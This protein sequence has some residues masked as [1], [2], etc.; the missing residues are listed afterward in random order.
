MQNYNQNYQFT[1]PVATD[2]N[3]RANI[4]FYTYLGCIALGVISFLIATFTSDCGGN[5]ENSVISSMFYNI[6]SF[7]SVI[8]VFLLFVSQ[9]LIIVAKILHPKDI[10]I[11]VAFIVDMVTVALF[12]LATLLVMLFM[13]VT[14][15]TCASNLDSLGNIG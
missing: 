9:V 7:T 1:Q 10:K 2:N 6:S 4:L 3:K 11:K 14:C 12:L 8:S 5:A 13:A 15:F